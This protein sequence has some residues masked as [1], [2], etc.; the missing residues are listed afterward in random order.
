MKK[1][2]FLFTLAIFVFFTNTI[3]AQ[4]Y[5][6]GPDREICTNS[7]Q[8]EAAS[9][10]SGY[11][12]TWSIES[13]GCDFNN[14]N[15][16]NAL[17]TNV[18]E[19]STVLIWTVTN[20]TNTYYD[21]VIITN[22]QVSTAQI[23]DDDEEICVDSC[24]IYG[25]E[26][27]DDESGLWKTTGGTGNITTPEN[28]VTE[29]TNIALGVN[30]FQWE[31]KKGN[32]TSIDN[33]V[34]TNNYIP[35]VQTNDDDDICNDSY[36]IYAGLYN[37]T[38]GL[39]S[40][41]EGYG[42]I[43]SPENYLTEVTNLDFGAN[44]FQWELSNGICR[45]SD[46]ITITNNSVTASAGQGQDVCTDEAQMQ[47]TNPVNGT[48][49]WTV[50]YSLG[51]PDFEDENNPTTNVSNL[52]NGYNS[53]LWTVDFEECSENS[54]VVIYNNKVTIANA[55]EGRTICENNINLSGNNST[56]GTGT[57]SVIL[58]TGIIENSNNYNTAVT[59]LSE[60]V[61]KF[62]WTI[63]NTPCSSY[64]EVEFF[65]K[66][67][68][69]DAGEDEAVCSSEY[70]L[71]ATQSVTGTGVWEAISGY[72][73]FDNETL[74]NTTVRNMLQGENT[75]LWTATEDD[76]S[77][78][79]TVTI[80]ND[81]PSQA[82]VISYKEICTDYTQINANEPVIGSGT[83]STELGHGIFSHPNNNATNISEIYNGENIYRWTITN[84][85]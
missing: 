64:D 38:T 65:Y 67:V 19:D 8:L 69:T 22:N 47:A 39:W 2:P 18:V 80:T 60:G 75:F 4:M 43:T 49:T 68:T 17:I 36:T 27:D 51:T 76:C 54:S 52:G 26:P 1:L 10:S 34:I 35:P 74:Y 58:G 77:A 85:D 45:S 42:E 40:L 55:G 46:N 70:Q 21:N 25:N 28:Y 30:T 81:N 20:G 78:S 44:T 61:N 9:A 32:C 29:V 57:W 59:D 13:G 53:F 41:I 14:I 63:V 37:N 12:G 15:L 11:I 3:Y 84:N 7:M 71:S 73:I 66:I 24:T 48:G 6:A 79:A 72:G 56:Y 62:R 83:W 16:P 50:V 33:I 23:D 5:N 31:H 82:S